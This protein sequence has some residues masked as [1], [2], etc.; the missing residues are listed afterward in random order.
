MPSS[1]AS[2]WSPATRYSKETIAAL[3]RC[4][5]TLF[6]S[7]LLLEDALQKVEAELGDVEEVRYF[8]EFVRGS[9]RGVCR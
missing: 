9:K 4:Y 8:V 7:N 5:T 2:R 6:N 1:A 3:K